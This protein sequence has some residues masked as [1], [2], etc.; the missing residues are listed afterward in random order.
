M[1]TLR[2]LI[3]EINNAR[4]ALRQSLKQADLTDQDIVSVVQREVK[5][6]REAAIGFRSGGRE[7]SAQKEEDEAAVLEGYLPEQ[8]SNEEL[9]KIV[10]ESITE[11]GVNSLADMGRVMGAVMGKVVGRA[12]GVAVSKL[13]KEKLSL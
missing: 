9:T 6:R 1:S 13:V 10:E 2:L 5:K 3:S 4:I 7:N 12:D 8:L 11:L